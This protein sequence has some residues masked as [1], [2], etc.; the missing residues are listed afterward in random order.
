M[1]LSKKRVYSFY[2]LAYLS[3]LIGFYYNEDTAGGQIQDYNTH[4]YLIKTLINEGIINFLLDYSS[5][6]VPHSPFY[7]LYILLLKK[8]FIYSE[9]V[10]LINLHVVLLLPIFFY[11]SLY[12]A[13]KARRKDLITVIPI[14]L[15]LSP[16]FRSGSIW[17]DD[18]ILGLTFF[19]ISI[20]FFIRLKNINFKNTFLIFFH[21]FFL[22]LASYFRP[23]YSVFSIYF[24]MQFMLNRKILKETL[25][26]IVINII[27]SFPAI[28]YVLI[29]KQNFWITSHILQYNIITA[30]SLS[31]SVIFFYS[32]PFLLINYNLVKKLLRLNYLRILSTA[33]YAILLVN[34][35][36]FDLK[37]SGG[38][39]YKFSKKIF[40]NDYFFIGLSI[41]IFYILISILKNKKYLNQSL[42]FFLLI[43]FSVGGIIYHRYYDPLLYII[44]F[45]LVKNPVYDIFNK[46]LSNIKYIF[47]FI[48]STLFYLLSVFK[49]YF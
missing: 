49:K 4:I 28:Y 44:F 14:L 5:K 33:V 26:Y 40:Q 21:V 20:Y 37:Y 32:I 34:Y 22:G 47:L 7:I 30:V 2:L 24:F 15:F 18:N 23:I 13:H 36:Y 3:L 17:I 35:F 43:F 19:T 25:L 42:I 1:I 6:F 31:F 27:I 9:I 29:L 11:K 38:V 39:L 41:I 16:Y 46:K 8:I 12:L 48:F 45:L 10:R